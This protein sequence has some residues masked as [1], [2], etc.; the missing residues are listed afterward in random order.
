[1]ALARG[2]NSGGL[3]GLSAGTGTE[4]MVDGKGKKMGMEAE[5][6]GTWDFDV[7]R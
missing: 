6:Y 3:Q 7:H 1:M 5:G 2:E 4:K